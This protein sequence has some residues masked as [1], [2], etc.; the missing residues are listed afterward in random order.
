MNFVQQLLTLVSQQ[1]AW[2]FDTYT[3]LETKAIG[4]LTFDGALGAFVA[5][6]HPMPAFLRWPFFVALVISA[7]ACVGSLW[8]RKVYAGP[9]VRVF[10]EWTAGSEDDEATLSLMATLENNYRKNK[11]ALARKGLYWTIAA[12]AL[13]VAVI[14]MGIDLVAFTGR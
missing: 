2:Q 3:S 10:Y 13:V 5:V 14:T 11:P 1:L 8:I 12:V 9:N 7:C 6:L 4:L